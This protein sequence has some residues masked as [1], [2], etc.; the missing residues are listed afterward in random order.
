MDDNLMVMQQTLEMLSATVEQQRSKIDELERQ[1]GNARLHEKLD[2]LVE[3][4]EA[5]QRQRGCFASQ[6]VGPDERFHGHVKL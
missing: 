3:Q 6:L 2:F 5:Q 1:N 4:A